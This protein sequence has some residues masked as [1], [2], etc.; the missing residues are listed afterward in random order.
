MRFPL[1]L[2]SPLSASHQSRGWEG[3]KP[4]K[5]KSLNLSISQMQ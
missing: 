1:L 3:P 5:Q 4:W 2:S